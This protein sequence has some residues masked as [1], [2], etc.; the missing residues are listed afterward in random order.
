MKKI[1][2]LLLKYYLKFCARLALS[3]HRPVII[4][5]AGSTNK[6]FTKEAI[7][8]TL[9][10]EGVIVRYHSKSFNT[11]I[12]LPLAILDI[13]S[14]YGD[15][16]AWLPIIP[17]A[18]TSILEKMPPVVILELGIAEPGDMKYLLSIIDPKIT[19]ITDITQRYLE[20]FSDMDELVDEYSLLVK[21]RGEEDVIC[22]NYDNRRVRTLSVGS[23]AKIITYGFSPE[24]DYA[25]SSPVKTEDGLDFYLQKPRQAKIR[26]G[27]FGDHHIYCE[28]CS[29]IIIDQKS[30]L[31][32]G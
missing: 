17:L 31:N 27:K 13:P 30:K 28:L 2:K 20:S 19:I 23:K 9:A 29:Q 25:A 1:L 7:A 5:I 12:S 8:A 32:A 15:Y 26:T 22:L 16:S 11:E 6:V 24:A 10:K 4:A 14:G 3:I 21:T 18:F